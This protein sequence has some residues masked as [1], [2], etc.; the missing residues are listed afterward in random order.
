[1]SPMQKEV[2]LSHKLRDHTYEYQNSFELKGDN[3]L[4]RNCQNQ[5]IH[6]GLSHTEQEC[7]ESLTQ[8]NI[9]NQHNSNEG[10]KYS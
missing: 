9:H 4:Q 2:L 3:L 6:P 8:G 10:F 7:Q 5:L 1:M